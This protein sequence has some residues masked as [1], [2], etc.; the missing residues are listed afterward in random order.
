MKPISLEDTALFLLAAII[1]L[2]LASFSGGINEHIAT[3]NLQQA[4]VASAIVPQNTN[5]SSVASTDPLVVLVANPGIVSSDESTTLSW[6]IS[7]DAVERCAAASEP[8]DELW[9]GDKQATEGTH[10]QDTSEITED[11]TYIIQC[12]DAN[13]R[14]SLSSMSV[15][16]SE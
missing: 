11:T 1:S 14:T 6:V 9:Q 5:T 13:G 3:N 16:V 4:Q 12:I 15:V 7:T 8:I 2:A 10:T